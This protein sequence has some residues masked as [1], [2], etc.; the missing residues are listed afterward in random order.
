MALDARFYKD[1][2]DGRPS[3]FG[4]IFEPSE[5]WLSRLPT[6]DVID[7]DLPIVDAHHHLWIEP[8]AYDRAAFEADVDSGHR[9][10]ATVAV[11]CHVAYRR[12]GP[13]ALYPVGET[14]FLAESVADQHGL[15]KV[16]AGIVGYADLSL[17][18]EI[19]PVLA[20]HIEA[21]RGRFRGVR[22]STGWDSSPDVA[23]TQ[24]GERPGMLRESRTIEAAR[25]LA[26]NGLTLDAWLFHPQLADVAVLADAV[27][28][29]NIVVDH[30]GGPL[31]YGPYARHRSSHFE[32][33]R[34]GIDLVARR[35]N[36]WC[37]VGGLLAR[38]AAID[39]VRAPAPP[40][41][42][43]LARTWFPWLDACVEAFGPDRC[44]FESN[45]PV[46]KMGT[47]YRV[48][49][50]AYKK[51]ASAASAYERARLF[52]GSARAFYRLG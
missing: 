10:D 1:A 48:L 2:V 50:N 21:G 8:Y 38:G 51:F 41:S 36:V 39:Y 27:P 22:F 30:C 47:T 3:E 28:E 40:T 18:A 44:M 46:D 5:H 49:W 20:G 6:E 12:T 42:D 11:E 34:A 7:P 52:S 45:F 31:G 4:T 32:R 17:G 29:L 35:P 19:E 13:E 15:T 33:W 23:N 16:A 24:T 37:K 9:V 26:R 25:V 43:D 14:E